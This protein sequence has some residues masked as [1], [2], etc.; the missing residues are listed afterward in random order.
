MLL[1]QVAH[2][3]PQSRIYH[4]YICVCVCVCLWRNFC[5][6]VR[7]SIHTVRWCERESVCIHFACVCKP[8]WNSYINTHRRSQNSLSFRV[9]GCLA[10]SSSPWSL[11]TAVS[12]ALRTSV[13]VLC[14]ICSLTSDIP[15]MLRRTQQRPTCIQHSLCTTEV[16]AAAARLAQEAAVGGGGPFVGSQSKWSISLCLPWRANWKSIISHCGSLIHALIL[17]TLSLRGRELLLWRSRTSNS[18]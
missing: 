16:D 11:L 15:E 10:A 7:A 8:V 4:V 5:V 3:G 18:K 13:A 2:Q 17:Q 6:C 12:Q 14:N 1:G 9:S